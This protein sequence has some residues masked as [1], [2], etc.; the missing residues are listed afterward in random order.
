MGTPKKILIVDDEKPILDALSI[1]LKADGLEIITA[2]TIEQAEYAIKNTSFNVVL[3]DIRLT[4]V[5]GREGLELLPYIA[6]KSPETKVIIMTAYGSPEIEEEAYN[7]G[8][9]FYFDKP[10]DLHILRDRLEE[11]LGASDKTI[12]NY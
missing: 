9:Y 1:A 4:G 12:S 6:E 11:L 3:A 8:A 5:L 10:I 7:K 2:S